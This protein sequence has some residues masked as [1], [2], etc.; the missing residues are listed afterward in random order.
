MTQDEKRLKE[1]KAR[2]FEIAQLIS[3]LKKELVNLSA[4]ERQINGYHRIERSRQLF[5]RKGRVKTRWNKN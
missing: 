1:I 5:S 3:K 2:K 4:E